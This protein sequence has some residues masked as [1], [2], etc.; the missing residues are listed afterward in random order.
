MSYE[1]CAWFT[2]TGAVTQRVMQPQLANNKARSLFKNVNNT[3][4]N[5]K[6]AKNIYLKKINKRKIHCQFGDFTKV[7]VSEHESGNPFVCKFSAVRKD[8]FINRQLFKLYHRCR[9]HS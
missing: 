1:T 3:I 6:N 2:E 8:D 5:L 9:T 7:Q 4:K